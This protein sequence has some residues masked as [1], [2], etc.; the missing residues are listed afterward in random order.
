MLQRIIAHFVLQAKQYGSCIAAK[1]PE[2][3][4]DMCL[5]EFI[6]LKNCMQK[7]V[8]WPGTVDLLRRIFQAFSCRRLYYVISFQFSSQI[9]Q[10]F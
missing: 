4:R 1:V 6:L 3:D 5:K 7:T 9:Q 2:I 10:K 8:L